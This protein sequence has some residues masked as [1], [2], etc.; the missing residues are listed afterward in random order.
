MISHR[1]VFWSNILPDKRSLALL[2]A[3][4]A[5]ALID[6]GFAP[7]LLASDSDETPSRP[8]I[9]LILADDLGYGDVSCYNSASKVQTP[10]IDHLASE[11]ML[12][13]DAHS[14][15]TVCTPTRYSVLTGRMAFRIGLRGVFAG[16]GGPCLIEENRLTLPGML[17]E[18]GY[19]TALIGKWHVG[20]TFFDADGEP[21]FNSSFAAAK[22]VDFSRV[23]PDSPVHRGFDQFFGTACCPT[24]DYIYSFIEGDRIPNPPTGFLDKSELPKHPYSFDNRPGLHSPD[25]DL[26]EVDQIFLKKSVQFLEQHSR[27]NP[28]QPF[29]LMHSTQAVHLPS[30]PGKAFQGKTEAGPHGDFIFELDAVVGELMETLKRLELD[31]NTMVIF[32][33]D[34]GPEVETVYHMRTDYKHDGARPWRGVKRDQWEG[35]HRTPFF[36]RWPGRIEPGSVSDQTIS[37]T[38][39]MATCS[40][41][42]DYELPPQAAED[43]FN[44]LPVLVG[45]QCESDPIRPYTLSQ[46]ISL[47]LAIRKGNWKYLDHKG[48]GGNNYDRESLIQWKIPEL[49]PQAPGQ[50][51]DL[52]NDPGE[53]RNLYFERPE[54]VGELKALLDVAKNSGRSRPE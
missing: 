17:R 33:S 9:L 25:F 42:V 53:T 41:I 27:S 3:C 11:G 18:Q 44:L 43:S 50:L 49:A 1:T 31:S 8:N 7:S 54:K 19:R 39:L 12:F 6:F 48:S 40:A 38:D 14:P 37:L 23:I 35:G 21:V 20:L 16:A 47:A 24:T 4:S 46:T 52:E 45:E 28:D 2:I 15:S 51:Y 10:N 36:V 26:E 5:A 29:F 13:T 32:A 34:N 22:R 30:F